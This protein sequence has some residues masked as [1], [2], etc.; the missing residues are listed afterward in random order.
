MSQHTEAMRRLFSEGPIGTK[1]DR[2]LP[3]EEAKRM[4][5]D[6]PEPQLRELVDAENA[7]RE[8]KPANPKQQYGDRKVPLHLVPSTALVAI[9]MG[10]KEGARK[11]GAFNWREVDVETMTYVG[12]IMRHLTAWV[13]GEELDAESG[14]PHLFHAMASLAILVDATESQKCTDNRPPAGAG[15]I[16]LYGYQER[17]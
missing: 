10:L 16:M 15:P 3:Y 5:P 12:A 6:V 14:N 7:A 4:Y 1:S 11:Y 13:E 17:P 2:N 9:A 8:E